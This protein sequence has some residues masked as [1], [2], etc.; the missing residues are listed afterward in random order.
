MSNRSAF[1]LFVLVILVWGLNWTVTKIIVLH[2]SPWWT[3]SLRC[4]VALTVLFA[5]QVASRQFIIPRRGDIPVVLSVGV[6]HM[7]SAAVFM[8]LGLQFVPVG[9]SAVLGYTTPLWVAPGAWLLL[10]EPMGA[11]RGAGIAL[12]LAGLAVLLNPLALNWNDSRSVAGNGFLLLSALSW[13]CSILYVRRHR[14]LATPFQLIFW[15][16][17][18]AACITTTAALA[19]EGIPSVTW[20]GELV[21]AVLYCGVPGT[22]FGFWAMTKINRSLPATVTALG[23]LG[24]PL[25]GATSSLVMLGEPIDLPLVA[26][27]VL[28]LGG[29]ALGILGKR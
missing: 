15:Q 18:L 21:W 7:T 3:A 12:G 16:C 20:T 1:L 29:I 2:L 28:I 27:G 17:L 4:L 26:A 6:L 8:A 23:S 19:L 11:M 5:V 24:V 14:W 22:A 10:K 25:V 9:R 13:A